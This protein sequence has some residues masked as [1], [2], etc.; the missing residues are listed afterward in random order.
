[1]EGLSAIEKALQ[2]ERKRRKLAEQLL[3]ERSREL[4]SSYEE[5]EHAHLGLKKNQKQLI[6]AEKMASLGILVAGVAHEINNPV[7]YVQSNLHTLKEYQPIFSEAFDQ[8]KSLLTL[9]S[10]SDEYKAAKLKIST[11]LLETDL[12]YLLKDIADLIK[13]SLDGLDRIV[14]IVKGLRTFSHTGDSEFL[15]IDINACLKVTHTLVKS[16]LRNGCTIDLDLQ[17]VPLVLGSETNLGQVFLNLMVNA[18]QSIQ[19]EKGHILLRSFEAD[20]QVV[21]EVQDNGC[22]ISEENLSKLFMPFFTTKPVGEGTGLGLSIS[23]GIIKDLQGRL[24]VTS[25]LGQGTKFVVSLPALQ[26]PRRLPTALP[27]H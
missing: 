23:F 9:D 1:M 27:M 10:S 22:G 7:G 12:D 4:F 5:L 26:N 17:P 18:T 20:S 13:E 21:V 25:K 2:R 16:Q 14:E 15:P 3:E 8:F 24:E 19:H 11:Y 6:H